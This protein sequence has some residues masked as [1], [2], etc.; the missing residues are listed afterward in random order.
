MDNLA[1]MGYIIGI[2]QAIGS[3]FSF[4]LTEFQLI[5]KIKEY[6]INAWRN[7]HGNRI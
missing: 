7:N 5:L 3:N 2:L 1:S 6:G 4:L